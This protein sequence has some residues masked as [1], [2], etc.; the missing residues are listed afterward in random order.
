[1]EHSYFIER[2][3]AFLDGDLPPYEMQVVEEHLQSCEECRAQLEQYRK[4]NDLVEQKSRL[5]DADYWEESAKKIEAAI[6]TTQTEVVELK[7]S[8]S[9]GLFWKISAVAASL[10]VITFISLHRSEIEEPVRNEMMPVE[11]KSNLE[12]AVDSIGREAKEAESKKSEAAGEEVRTDKIDAPVEQDRE[13][14]VNKPSMAGEGSKNKSDRDESVREKKVVGGAPAPGRTAPPPSVTNP[15]ADG[16]GEVAAETEGQVVTIFKNKDQLK[17]TTNELVSAEKIAVTKMASPA[18]SA[19]MIT[20]S[21][22]D[23]ETMIQLL[24]LRERLDSL[25]ITI[26]KYQSDKFA[27][28][29]AVN[30]TGVAGAPGDSTYQEMTDSII[31]T[32]YQIGILSSDSAEI[33]QSAEFLQDFPWRI[34]DL[35]QSRINTYVDEI[36]N[37][38]KK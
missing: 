34:T 20:D 17:S 16:L 38:R 31:S 8:K 4:L 22:S 32:V 27:L 15:T 14:S 35:Q 7:P 18:A 5:D 19:D 12:V 2:L 13:L 23:D 11:E 21:V 1:M 26:L 9:S 30:T 37:R 10:A 36:L 33:D 3:S 25:R 6:G 28:D 24:T 29:R